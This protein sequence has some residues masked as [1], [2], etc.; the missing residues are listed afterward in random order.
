MIPTLALLTTIPFYLAE[1]LV[2]CDQ[3]LTV[4]STIGTELGTLDARTQDLSWDYDQIM[5]SPEMY[6]LSPE[7][8]EDLESYRKE[9]QAKLPTYLEVKAMSK[10]EKEAAYAAT[11]EKL[12]YCQGRLDRAK[13][14][15]KD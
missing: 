13:S 15:T 3:T 14:L 7:D 6:N 9:V 8:K 2:E 11:S 10:K 12:D 5:V 1:Q 4:R